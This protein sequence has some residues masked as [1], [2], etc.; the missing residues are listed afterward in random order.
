MTP[1]FSKHQPSSMSVLP[2]IKTKTPLACLPECCKHVFMAVTAGTRIESGRVTRTAPLGATIWTSTVSAVSDSSCKSALSMLPPSERIFRVQWAWAK[3]MA[4]S[5]G[6]IF[7]QTKFR[8]VQ[9]SPQD[10]L[11]F[12]KLYKNVSEHM[13]IGPENWS[14]LVSTHHYLSNSR[15]FSIMYN[16]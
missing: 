3:S 15:G 9:E 1:T 13:A 5:C 16:V 11:H 2:N 12:E 14:L 6:W 4:N 10:N 8:G 7:L